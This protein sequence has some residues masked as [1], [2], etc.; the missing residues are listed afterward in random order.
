MLYLLS[1]TRK[2]APSVLYCL[3]RRLF[4]RYRG[5]KPNAAF[6]VAWFAYLLS[7]TRKRAPSVLYCLLRRLF[8]RYRGKKPNAAFG[9]AWF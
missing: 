9:V 7:Q 4:A 3:L 2:R 1:Q 6:G 5:K 8:A